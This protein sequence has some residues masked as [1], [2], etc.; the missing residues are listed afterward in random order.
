MHEGE[1]R[2]IF[3]R[4]LFLFRKVGIASQS[5]PELEAPGFFRFN[6]WG[7]FFSKGERGGEEGAHQFL[8]GGK[9]EEP[10]GGRI[11]IHPLKEA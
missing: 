2:R 3:K 9:E 11:G 1:K 6:E 7:A 4:F 5:H 10:S 8:M